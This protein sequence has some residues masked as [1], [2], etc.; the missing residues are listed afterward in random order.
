MSGWLPWRNLKVQPRYTQSLQVAMIRSQC[1]CI[2]LP[3]L[4]IIFWKSSLLVQ[5]LSW[6]W[7]HF[8][9]LPHDYSLLC[10]RSSYNSDRCSL[11]FIILL[12][13]GE[14]YRSWSSTAS[15][16][17][18]LC[19][20]CPFHTYL[21]S[22]QLCFTTVVIYLPGQWIAAALAHKLLTSLERLCSVTDYTVL[23]TRSLKSIKLA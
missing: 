20:L 9:R 7:L 11:G 6:M 1:H 16:F 3:P 5:F 15:S 4:K 10:P 14:L 21:C 17:L 2:H 8:R 23:P 12:V 18:T 22:W 13:L 19:Q